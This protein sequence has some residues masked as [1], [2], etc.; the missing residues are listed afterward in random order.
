[1]YFSFNVVLVIIIKPFGSLKLEDPEEYPGA[2][3]TLSIRG[4]RS[5]Q[6]PQ[7]PNEW[8]G[9]QVQLPLGQWDVTL[10]VESMGLKNP[11]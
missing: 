10:K 7:T 3:G 11:E 9:G 2:M 5:S 1:M 4:V 8:K 6:L